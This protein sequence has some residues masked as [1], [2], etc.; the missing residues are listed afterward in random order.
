MNTRLALLLS[1]C[2]FLALTGCHKEPLDYR[3]KFLGDYSFTIHSTYW[4]SSQ[5][6]DT[7]YTQDGSIGYG[8]N[9]NSIFVSINTWNPIEFEI[10][11]DGT[12][13]MKTQG[14]SSYGSGEFTSTHNVVF[15]KGGHGL[16]GGGLSKVTG[17]KK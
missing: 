2:L 16:G 1:S 7:T 6:L 8:S 15:S 5:S 9:I 17:N 13:E 12:I 11:E 3:N 14:T 4:D 10:Y